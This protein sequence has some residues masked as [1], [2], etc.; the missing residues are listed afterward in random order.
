MNNHY[1]AV[2][3]TVVHTV[4]N[5]ITEHEFSVV[6]YHHQTNYFREILRG[7]EPVG[8]VVLFSPLVF[9]QR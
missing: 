7:L 2:Y 9:S 4:V 6:T 1:A 8:F 5:H 3:M